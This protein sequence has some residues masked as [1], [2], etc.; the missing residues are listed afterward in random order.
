MPNPAGRST[1]RILVSVAPMDVS[2]LA[3]VRYG[4]HPF[5]VSFGNV[6]DFVEVTDDDPARWQEAAPP[7]FV[8]AALFV[9]AP[10]LLGQLHDHSVI[11]GEQTFTWHSPI[12]ISDELSVSGSVGRVRERGGIHFVAFDLE[13][14]DIEGLV[15]EGTSRFLISADSASTAETDERAEPSPTDRGSVADGHMAASRADLVRYA[16]ATRDWN[17]VHWDH[18]AGMAAGFGGVVVHGL[19]QASWAFTTASRF[20]DSSRPLSS[21]RVRFRNP[22]PPATPVRVDVDEGASTASVSVTDGETE[23]TSALIELAPE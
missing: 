10:D 21:A 11:H 3:G 6:A 23:Y 16:A 15:A 5:H 17:P 19:L 14:A 7:G 4:P 1:L 9:V 20:R 22:L 13:V 18:A 12:E 8:A 2:S